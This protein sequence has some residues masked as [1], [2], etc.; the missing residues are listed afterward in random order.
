MVILP[1]TLFYMVLYGIIVKYC[2]YCVYNLHCSFSVLVVRKRWVSN[3][4]NCGGTHLGLPL[5]HIG[6]ERLQEMEV[7]NSLFDLSVTIK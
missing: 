6:L 3:S 1:V 7:L 5:C 4:G 2:I